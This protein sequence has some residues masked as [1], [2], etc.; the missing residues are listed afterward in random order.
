MAH[1][2]FEKLENRQSDRPKILLPVGAILLAAGLTQTF[3]SNVPDAFSYYAYGFPTSNYSPSIPSW[4]PFYYPSSGGFYPWNP[5]SWWNPSSWWNPISSWNP[6][7]WW[8]PISSWNPSSWWNP[9]SWW[10][11]SS[12]WNPA[13]WNPIPWNPAPWDAYPYPVAYYGVGIPYY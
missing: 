13:P 3:L 7:S 8:N 6:T 9:T 5:T 1:I 2:F 11:P 4:D 12:W 10:N